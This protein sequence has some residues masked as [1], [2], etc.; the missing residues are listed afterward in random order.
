[1]SATSTKAIA[2]LRPR[3]CR[4]ESVEVYG[5]AADG[6]EV[7]WKALSDVFDL[8]N[9][10]T[11]SKSKREYWESGAVP[12]FRMDDLCQNGSILSDSLQKV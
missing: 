11:P 2:S 10:Y 9:G 3:S 4:H 8:K 12:W 7:E 6:V 1:M 5:K